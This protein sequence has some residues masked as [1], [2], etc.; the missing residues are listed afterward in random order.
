LEVEMDQF[1]DLRD[2]SY[3][4]LRRL[5]RQL[6]HEGDGLSYQRRLLHG[7]IDILRA[8]LETR[9]RESGGG[10]P[11][12]VREPRRPSPQSGSQTAAR[13]DGEDAG[14]ARVHP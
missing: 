4:E 3:E 6:E 7:R 5:I 8:E 2:L 10:D 9:G 13:A 14:S 11:S 1:P 12:G